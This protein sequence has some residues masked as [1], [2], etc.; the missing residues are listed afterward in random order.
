MP[1]AP[2]SLSPSMTSSGIL[3]SRSIC[4]GSTLSTRNAR[5]LSRKASPFS[6]AA[7]S[8]LGC[9]WMR[10]SL[11]LPRNSPLPK[12]GSFQSRSRA[13]SATCRAS[14]SLT[15]VAMCVVLLCGG[16]EGAWHALHAVD[17]GGALEHLGLAGL[18]VGQPREQLGEDRAQLRAGQ[19][20]AQTVVRPAA[21]EADVMIGVAGDVEGPWVREGV[22]VPVARV[23][24]E[25]D[26]LALADRLAVQLGVARGG[27]PEGQHRRRPA[28]ELLDGG[29]RVLED[30]L[31]LVGV[32]RELAHRVRR[33]V[34]RRVVA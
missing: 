7:G 26:L 18:D 10:S 25:H 12:L 33:G 6:T 21:A 5:S 20:R 9:G 19:R 1:S 30:E 3:A 32:Q 2:S 31:A 16:R 22:V 34:A 4:S 8:S 15:S 29:G 13:S 24:E 14:L 27:P 17:E 23:V 28:H 11:K